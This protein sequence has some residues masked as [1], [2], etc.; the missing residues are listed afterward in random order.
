[1]LKLYNTLTKQIEN[2]PYKPGNTVNLYSCGPTVYNYAHIGN[3]RAFLFADTLNRALKWNDLNVN[4]VMNITDVDDKTIRDTIKQTGPNATVTDLKNF[5]TNY[6][7]L[8][9]E[10]L[11]KLGVN[12]NEITF[13]NVTDHIPEIQDFILK[14]IEK[15]YAY[16]A[17][18][19]STYFNI[20]KYQTEF[21]DYGQLVG[22]NFLKGKKI[23][24]RVA[25]DEYEKENLSD[26][27][28]WKAHDEN[29]AQ[30]FWPH[31][32]LGNGRPGWHIECS[33]INQIA[34]QN[35]PTD[36]HTGGVDLMFPHHTNE[37]AQSQPIYKP[38]V[39]TWCHSEHLLVE[40][41]KMSKRFQN[42]YTL[43]DIE[44][45]FHTSPLSYRYLTLQSHYQS[46]TNFTEES[47]KGA[48]TAIHKLQ[49]ISENYTDT[50]TEAS[51]QTQ[52]Y[53][54]QFTE[55]I[56]NDLNTPRALGIMWE[57]LA[58]NTVTE[59]EKAV[60]LKKFNAIFGLD[61]TNNNQITDIPE[62]IK[63]LLN[64][65]QIARDNKNFQKSDQLRHQ[66]E[67]LGY[68]IE[69]TKDGQ[70]ARKN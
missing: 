65:R 25:V 8:F 1:M 9:T 67:S 45:K 17:D 24:A 66:I 43:N 59:N 5:T 39:K 48:E 63:S 16:T 40:G 56:N 12:P 60:T 42:F 38:F 10:D 27:A 41:R 15:G 47:L 11:K 30:I 14:L 57:M 68:T 2:L 64:E 22:N 49:R 19:G 35:N 44:Q 26:F 51:E 21:G 32:K 7:K 69:D 28:L 62:Q 3:H 31:E 6:T 34:F 58:D 53:I 50:N 13:I 46:Q 70:K 37:I 23:G 54:N 36:I 18:D 33:V 52:N 61:L 29:D 4:W 20:E 55:A